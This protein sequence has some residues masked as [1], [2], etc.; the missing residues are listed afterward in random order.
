M[1]EGE[2][3]QLGITPQ[4]RRCIEATS[5]CYTVCTETLSYSLDDGGAFMDDRHLRLLI[6]AGEILQATQNGLLRLSELSTMLAAVCAEICEKVAE[7]CRQ[8]D[9]SDPQLIAC[10]ETCEHT[11]SCCHALAL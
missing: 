2:R 11:A 6:D 3:A 7:S 4:M 9:G 1:A 8:L 10:A 5:A